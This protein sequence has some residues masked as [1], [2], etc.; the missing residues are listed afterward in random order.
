MKQYKILFLLLILSS[1][2]SSSNHILS[3]KYTAKDK[4]IE[5]LGKYLLIRSNLID[6]EFDLYNVN[7]NNRS[8]PGPTDID[9]HIALK[10]TEDDIEKWLTDVTITSFPI[11]YAWTDK[12]IKDNINFSHAS[13][14]IIYS[15]KNREI[16][17]YKSEGVLFLHIYQH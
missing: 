11:N 2:T 7:I 10:V 14:P 17:L 3:T 13:N 15:G 6:V 12:L 5:I 9:Y 8:I 4:K 16:I 1:C